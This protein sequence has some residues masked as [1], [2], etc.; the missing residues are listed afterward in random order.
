[1]QVAGILRQLTFDP[2]EG[3]RSSG[4]GWGLNL[5]GHVNVLPEVAKGKRDNLVFQIAGGQGIANYFND[6]SGLGQ[7]GF[8]KANGDLAVLGIWGGF[9]AYQHF[10]NKK[11]GSSLGYSYLHV[12]GASGQAGST[13]R[14]GHYVVANTTYYPAERVWIGLEALYG[15]REDQDGSTG[16]DG[17]LSFSVQYRF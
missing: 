17:R 14:S 16:D 11:W 10:W 2:V 3:S 15:I 1:L 5:S 6:T 7:D 8:V 9:A 4:I 12:D 13:Y